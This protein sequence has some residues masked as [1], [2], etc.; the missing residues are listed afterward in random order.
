MHKFEINEFVHLRVGSRILKTIILEKLAEKEGLF[1][2][3]NWEIC[4][5]NK[6]LNTVRISEKSIKK[7]T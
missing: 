2:K 7:I 1:Y 5:Y 6:I 4:G 3:L